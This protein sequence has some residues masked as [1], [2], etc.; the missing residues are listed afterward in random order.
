[1]LLITVWVCAVPSQL[2]AEQ[3]RQALDA[4]KRMLKEQPKGMLFTHQSD[5]DENGVFH[6]L[7]TCG[8]SQKWMNPCDAGF[9]SLSSVGMMGDSAPLSAVGDTSC[10]HSF[11]NTRLSQCVLLAADHSWLERNSCDVSP[12]LSVTRGCLLIWWT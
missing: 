5:M 9:V 8:K 4:V 1:M 2:E 6:Y 12:S 10:W 11:C 7:G 3:K